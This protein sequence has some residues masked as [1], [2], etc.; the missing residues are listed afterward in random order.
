MTFVVEN[1]TGV[2]GANSYVTVQEFRD[3]HEL[4]GRSTAG[5]TQA[6]AQAALVLATDYVDFRWG[7]QFLGSRRFGSLA[8]RAVFSLTA[9][10]DDG[11][12]VTFGDVTYV[13]RTS[14]VEENE[15]EIGSTILITLANLLSVLASS[16]N[17]DFA[18]GE[19]ADPD[20]AA[21]T[22][23]AVR[24]G[25]ATA[26]TGT[27]GTWDVASTAGESGRGQPL[28]FPRVQLRDRRGDLVVGIPAQL[29]E[30]VAEYAWR[31]QDG[32]ALAPD[33]VVSDTGQRITGQ[34]ERVGPIETETT[35]SAWTSA[36]P[37]RPYPAADRLLREFI[38][39]DGLVRA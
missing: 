32:S 13:F 23:F 8:S 39:A 35:Y 24:D 11:D 28:E 4:R 20:V 18:G 21:L 14:E 27:A 26:A 34:R 5:L 1:G 29:R 31:A 17:D 10:P 36:S 22:V 33:P 7:P 19:F 3:Y 9:Q 38:R 6:Q 2:R 37:L 12:E 30:A 16:E 15:V 25:V